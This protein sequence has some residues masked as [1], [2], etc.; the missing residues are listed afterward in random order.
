MVGAVGVLETRRP[1][2]LCIQTCRQKNFLWGTMQPRSTRSLKQTAVRQGAG[3]SPATRR[4]TCV[5]VAVALTAVAVAAAFV[6]A[7]TMI[8]PMAVPVPVAVPVAV[9]VAVAVPAVAVAVPQHEQVDEVH[10]A[11]R[12]RQ[13]EHHCQPPPPTNTALLEASSGKTGC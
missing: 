4:A 2:K 1:V 7:A 8:V 10:A 3:R 5:A 6:A 12:Q 9:A 13:E 11:P